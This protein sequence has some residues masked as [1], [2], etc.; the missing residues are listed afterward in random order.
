MSACDV[1]ALVPIQITGGAYSASS[2]PE[3]DA[4]RILR[5]GSPEAAWVSGTNYPHNKRVIRT[6]THRVYRDTMGGVS[7]VV[8]ELDKERWFDEGPTNK[9]AWTDDRV[10]TKTVTDSPFTFSALP[11]AF[12]DLEFFG[13]ENVTEIDVEMVASG[14]VVFEETFGLEEYLGTDPHWELYFEAPRYGS[15]LSV[16]GMPVYPGAV[17]NVEIRNATGQLGV[18]LVGFGRYAY[19]GKAELGFRISYRD[20]GYDVTDK[21]G[22]DDRIPGH[23]A[24]DLEGSTLISLDEANGVDKTLIS[25]LDRGA[26][27]AVALATKYRFLKTWGR[28]QPASIEPINAIEARVSVKAKGLI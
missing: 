12:T 16:P 9:W 22:N 25:L 6:T 28:L 20:Y 7:T 8:P 18:G 19:M 2:V 26:I 23:K 24:K 21:Y 27:F 5:D 10:N 4:S 3:P 1:F 14:D 15:S 17:V 13:L 11:G